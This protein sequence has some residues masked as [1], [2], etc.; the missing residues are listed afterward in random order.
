M[1]RAIIEIAD[2]NLSW[3]EYQSILGPYLPAGTYEQ[4]VYF[5][6]LAFDHIWR[7]D[8]DALD[9]SCTIAWFISE[10]KE[11]LNQDRL[12]EPCRSRVRELLMK[13]VSRFEVVHYDRDACKAKGWSLAYMDHVLRGEAICEMLGRLIEFQVHQDLAIEFFEQLTQ[14]LGDVN[15]AA[16]LLELWR[17]QGDIY[18]PPNHERI[19]VLLNGVDHL[20]FAAKT[21]EES[22]LV[23]DAES[24]T[25][26]PT[27][28][29][30]LVGVI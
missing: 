6:P 1:T 23:R 3:R 11:E 26:W 17:A 10:Y 13:W 8:E 20:R 29:A 18:H 4:S 2:P 27:Q 28:F 22:S 7:H 30:S 5:L 12:I 25:Y 21:L 19:T 16:W 24:P 14:D 9:L 15:H